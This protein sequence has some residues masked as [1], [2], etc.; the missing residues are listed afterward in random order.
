MRAERFPSSERVPFVA[1]CIGAKGG[2]GIV[3]FVRLPKRMQEATFGFDVRFSGGYDWTAGGKLPGVCSESALHFQ[4]FWA[5]D[6][7]AQCWRSNAV[8]SRL[9]SANGKRRQRA[10]D[11][12]KKQ[13]R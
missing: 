11:Y 7:A 10:I 12:G 8:H 9:V 4:E 2:C 1:D 6:F 5:G 13:N 3:A